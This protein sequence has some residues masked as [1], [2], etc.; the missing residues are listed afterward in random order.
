MKEINKAESLELLISQRRNGAL[1]WEGY[2]DLLIRVLLLVL[3]AWL[4][5][6]QVFFMTQAKGNDMFPAVKDGDLM[7]GFRLQREYNKNDVVLYTAEGKQHVGRILARGT[8]VV[9]LDESGTV[10]VNGTAQSGE[11][12]YPT[13]A[14]EETEYPLRIPEDQVF[15]LG[16]YRTQTVDSREFGTIPV[17]NVKGKVITILRRRGL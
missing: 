6:S 15:I 17:K 12:M 3:T 8:D 11:I 7:I 16:D 1:D 2:R 9:T 14:D 4:L 5:L 10:L 13:Y